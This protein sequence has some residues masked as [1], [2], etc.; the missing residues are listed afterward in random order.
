MLM[1]FRSFIQIAYKMLKKKL[2]VFFAT[3]NHPI[4]VPIHILVG[5]LEHEF[6]FSIIY[7]NVIIPTD[8]VIFFRGIETTNQLTIINHY[9]PL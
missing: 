7:G 2:G 6:Y 3:I 5:G 8:E 9:K 4:H 1:E